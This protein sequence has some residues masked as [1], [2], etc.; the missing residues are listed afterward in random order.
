MHKNPNFRSSGEQC[1]A[2]YKRM[3][4]ELLGTDCWSGEIK[5]R[6]KDGSVYTELMNIDII[7]NSK[8][9]ITNYIGISQ[10]IENQ[11]LLENSLKKMAHY[12]MLTQVPNRSL[13]F[14]RLD[15]ATQRAL[16]EKTNLGVL[17]IDLD[18]FKKIND[19]KGHSAG[20][21]VLKEVSKRLSK[22]VRESDTVARFGGDEFVVLLEKVQDSSDIDTIAEKII[23][24]VSLPISHAGSN[25]ISSVGVSLGISIY[26]LHTKD[27][28]ELL[29][30]AD[31]AMY[32][33][34]EAG[35][36]QYKIYSN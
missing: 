10:S 8:R 19:F 14:D 17:F 35:K 31:M 13:F 29:A 16:R 28:K 26:P 6:H 25:D 4:D 7:R 20:D 23:T 15:K 12:D 32:E 21:D 24:E 36:N 30:Y 33:A 3:W 2:F 1:S 5:N 22:I 27:K 9:E 34:K 11:K 18:D